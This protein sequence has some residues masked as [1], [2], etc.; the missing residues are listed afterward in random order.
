[1]K[2]ITLKINDSINEKFQQLL[3]H[4]G[5][6]EIKILDESGYVSDDEYLR[7]IP[8]MVESIKAARNE[9][10]SHGVTADKLDW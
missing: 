3:R 10:I 8:G 7:S 4:F 6:G 2:T 1:M 9:P 5:E